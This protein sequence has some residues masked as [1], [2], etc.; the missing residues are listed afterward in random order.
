MIR[1]SCC[2]G[3][4]R[5]ELT[6]PPMMMATCH[7]SR[8]RK[9]G[10]SAFVFVRG[11]SFRWVAGEDQVATYAPPPPYK[12]ARRFCRLCGTAL[13]EPDP[14]QE[15]FPLNAHCLDDDPGVR[16]RFHEF[17]AEKPAWYEIADEAKQFAEHPVKAVG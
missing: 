5:F 7:C 9:A 1:G 8:C 6:A 14:A 2:C 12:H 10:A 13:G 16:N 17:V 4:V 15:S 11:E 3:A